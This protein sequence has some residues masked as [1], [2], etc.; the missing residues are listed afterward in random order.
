METFKRY[1]SYRD[2]EELST[3]DGCWFFTGETGVCHD[4]WTMRTASAAYAQSEAAGS[5][6]GL[7]FDGLAVVAGTDTLSEISILVPGAVAN[8][9]CFRLRR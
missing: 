3:K 2:M 5:V 7:D 1:C 6:P 4:I 9:R 8:L